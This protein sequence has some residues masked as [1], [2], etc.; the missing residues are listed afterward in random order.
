MVRTEVAF[1]APGMRCL[2][3]CCPQAQKEHNCKCTEGAT[4]RRIKGMKWILFVEWQALQPDT[5]KIEGEYY[6]SP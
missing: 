4:R 6:S 5:E 3:F 1:T 2:Q